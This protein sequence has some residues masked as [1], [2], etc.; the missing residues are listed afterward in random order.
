MVQ[1]SDCR[2]S[3]HRFEAAFCI[4][5]NM[6][7]RDFISEKGFSAVFENESQPDLIIFFGIFDPPVIGFFSPFDDFGIEVLD[8]F[9]RRWIRLQREV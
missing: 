4:D 9:G 5:N 2:Y 8:R 1:L 7:T 6:L 3:V